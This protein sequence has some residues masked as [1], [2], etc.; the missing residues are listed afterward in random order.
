MNIELSRFRVKDGKSAVVDE[1]LRFL[2]DNM[3]R[4]IR[5]EYEPPVGRKYA[6]IIASLSEI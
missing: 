1:W 4:V 6:E 3:A 2:N 5:E